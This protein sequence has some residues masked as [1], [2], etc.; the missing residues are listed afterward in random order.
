MKQSQEYSLTW[1]H[2]HFVSAQQQK[3]RQ[4]PKTKKKKE[5]HPW[6]HLNTQSSLL[7]LH[8]FF[9]IFCICLLFFFFLD[10]LLV[11]LVWVLFLID[12]ET[13]RCRSV[14]KSFSHFISAEEMWAPHSSLLSFFQPFCLSLKIDSFFPFLF[15]HSFLTQ[16]FSSSSKKNP[17]LEEPVRSSRMVERN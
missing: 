11:A 7:T 1:H 6:S 17:Q 3:K 13:G 14:C 16:F 9:S 4:K 10:L 2:K 15:L 8:F 5:K 12:V